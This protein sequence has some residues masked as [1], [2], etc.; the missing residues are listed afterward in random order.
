MK[1]EYIFLIR[2]FKK[3]KLYKER[4]EKVNGLKI[5]NNKEFMESIREMAGEWVC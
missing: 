5:F 4:G 1:S 3:N 2:K